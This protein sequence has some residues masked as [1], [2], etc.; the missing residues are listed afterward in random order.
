MKDLINVNEEV[1]SIPNDYDDI[2]NIALSRVDQVKK[3]KEVAIKMTNYNDWINMGDKP[4]LVG[5]GAEKI[6]RMFGVKI[7]DT[8]YKKEVSTDENGSFYFYVYTG[9][10]KLANDIDGIEC[11][12]TCSSKDSFFAKSGGEFKKISEVD[13]TNIMKS[14][15]TNMLQ[16]GITRLLGLRNM[17]WEEL[18]PA[19]IEKTKTSSVNYDKTVEVEG[20]DVKKAKEEKIEKIKNMI[21]E[22]CGNDLTSSKEKLL[23]YTSFIGKDGKEVKGIESTNLMKNWKFQRVTIIYTSVKKDY[24]DFIKKSTSGQTSLLDEKDK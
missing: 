20:D 13:E 1:L 7:T 12:G 17:T 23:K 11:V 4:Y 2:L 6:G 10:A 3:L 8:K 14:A 19:G 15:Y 16:N 21:L 22:M 9:I 5:A 24:D 18:K